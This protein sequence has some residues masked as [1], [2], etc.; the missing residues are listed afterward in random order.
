MAT[1]SRAKVLVLRRLAE[2]AQLFL[3]PTGIR[4][5]RLDVPGSPS[6]TFVAARTVH[7]LDSLGLIEHAA[8]SPGHYV[9]TIA[10]IREAA[11]AL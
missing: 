7:E 3:A 9:L 2:G 8:S 5:W 10:G 11:R 6:R 1:I 4:A